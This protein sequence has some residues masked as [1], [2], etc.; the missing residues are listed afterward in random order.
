MDMMHILGLC[1]FIYLAYCTICKK[2]ESNRA[3]KRLARRIYGRYA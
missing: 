1:P 3:A 2:I